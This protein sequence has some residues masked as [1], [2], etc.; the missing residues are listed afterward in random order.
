MD[1]NGTTY[2]DTYGTLYNWYAIKTAKLCPKGWHVPSNA[3]WTTLITYLGGEDIAGEK[4]R[5]KGFAHWRDAEDDYYI[6]TNGSGFTALPDGQFH[7]FSR[8]S[9][10]CPNLPSKKLYCT[11][12]FLIAINV[13]FLL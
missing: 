4:M 1:Y 12:I 5:E 2:K 7:W 8:L 13:L 6:A 3:E 9:F 10:H 11:I